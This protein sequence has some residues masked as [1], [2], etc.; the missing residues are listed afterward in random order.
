MDLTQTTGE[1]L[2]RLL[3]E[4]G[5]RMQFDSTPIM[6]DDLMRIGPNRPILL[7]DGHYGLPIRFGPGSDQIGVQVPGEEAIRW[8]PLTAIQITRYQA[9]LEVPTFKCDIC[10]R[11][12]AKLTQPVDD[13]P[14]RSGL[15][16]VGPARCD[17][18]AEKL[19]SGRYEL[20]QTIDGSAYLVQVGL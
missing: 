15:I 8:L 14:Y 7:L 12:A 9:L 18:C 5:S 3:W 16:P 17:A 6:V 4:G 13:H 20:M 1:E 11:L 10:G 19:R 2:L